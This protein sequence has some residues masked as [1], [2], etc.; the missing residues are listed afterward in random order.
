MWITVAM[1][2][3]CALCS[4]TPHIT[5]GRMWITPLSH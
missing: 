4:A 2:K 1:P 3:N 5:F